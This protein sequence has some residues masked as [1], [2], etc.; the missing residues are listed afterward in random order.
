MFSLNHMVQGRQSPVDEDRLR[1][2]VYR[3]KQARFLDRRK[4][5]LRLR[6]G[7]PVFDAHP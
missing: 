2:A 7:K 1:P 6:I 5:R 3:G 4:R